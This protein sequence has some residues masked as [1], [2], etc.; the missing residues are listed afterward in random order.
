[1]VEGPVR[2][3]LRRLHDAPGRVAEL[4]GDPLDADLALLNDAGLAAARLE[5]APDDALDVSRLRGRLGCLPGT[6]RHVSRRDS[7]QPEQ[8]Y[9]ARV[10]RSLEQQPPAMRLQ[11]PRGRDRAGQHAG[12]RHGVGD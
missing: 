5:V 12:G 11:E 8:G 9:A 10:K 4:D 6:T 7:G 1:E 2:I 3:R